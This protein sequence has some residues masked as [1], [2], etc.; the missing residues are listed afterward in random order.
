MPARAH[1]YTILRKAKVKLQNENYMLAGISD[2]EG[3]KVL[4]VNKHEKTF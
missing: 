4:V 3:R 1:L 2:E